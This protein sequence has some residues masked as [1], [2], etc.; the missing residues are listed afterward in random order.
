MNNQIPSSWRRKHALAKLTTMQVGGNAEFFIAVSTS[1]ALLEAYRSAQQLGFS[2]S[3]LAGGSNTLIA[4]EGVAGLV[5]HIQTKGMVWQEEGE[6]V[7]VE[8]EAGER[9]Q[10]FVDACL[11][12]NLGGVECLSGIP[13]SVGATP[14]QNVGAY[15][16]EVSEIIERVL[17]YDR[18]NDEERWWTNQECQFAYRDSFFKRQSGRFLVLKVAFRL[19]KNANPKLSYRELVNAVG[20]SPTLQHVASTVESL[21]RKK[22][23][24]YDE[25][26][27]NHRSAGSF[28]VNPIVDNDLADRVEK[29][30][31]SLGLMNEDE[32]MPSYPAGDQSKIAAAWLIERAGFSKGFDAGSVGISSKHSLG[33]INRG[34]ATCDEVLRF[35]EEIRHRVAAVFGVLLEREPRIL[36]S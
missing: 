21:R 27:P 5:I 7:V 36:G 3:F 31:R 35:A 10:D 13:G 1:Q 29:K 11:E 16:Q 18:K 8:A 4:D 15:G 6:F 34:D 12:R 19:Q 32:K 22:S 28:F 33:V 30:A 14:I 9:W 20:D 24:I 17:V 2:V 25:S 23:M 26:D